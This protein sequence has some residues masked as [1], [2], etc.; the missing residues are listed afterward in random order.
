M[1]THWASLRQTPLPHT[2][3]SP[4]HSQDYSIGPLG[5]LLSLQLL[6]ELRRSPCARLPTEVCWS[7]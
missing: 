6:Q 5:S 1:R 4:H 3:C 2:L 7:Q